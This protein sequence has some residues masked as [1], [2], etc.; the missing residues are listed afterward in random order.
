MRCRGTEHGNSFA[1]G[2]P[3][4]ADAVG[5]G[6]AARHNNALVAARHRRDRGVGFWSGL[7]RVGHGVAGG[8]G[9]RQGVQSRNVPLLALPTSEPYAALAGESRCFGA[10]DGQRFS[11]VQCFELL[12]ARRGPPAPGVRPASGGSLGGAG[13]FHGFGWR[14]KSDFA[15]AGDDFIHLADRH[16]AGRFG[17]DAGLRPAEV[18]SD[19]EPGQLVGRHADC[20]FRGDL[21]GFARVVPALSGHATIAGPDALSFP[22]S[23]AIFPPAGGR[24]KPAER[25]N[26]SDVLE[27]ASF[28][29]DQLHLQRGLPASACSRFR[30]GHSLEKQRMEGRRRDPSPDLLAGVGAHTAACGRR[31]H[32]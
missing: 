14:I 26:G 23:I 25:V 10:G 12:F 8:G 27:G 17:A 1:Q 13:E 5:A 19:S 30:A 3:A 32:L 28:A 20:L 31:R 9:F 22:A 18:V 11:G 2:I 7:F 29:A 4:A 15:V 16:S 21:P 24:A 6:I